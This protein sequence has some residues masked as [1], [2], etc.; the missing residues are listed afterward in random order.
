M[1]D[2]KNEIKNNTLAFIRRYIDRGWPV[3]PCN[4]LKTPRTPNGFYDAMTDMVQIQDWWNEYP[5]ALVGVPTGAVSGFWVIDIDM[6]DGKD[7]WASFKD[8]VLGS[9]EDLTLIQRTAS[10]GFHLLFKWNDE[11]PMNNGVDIFGPKSG[12]D[13]RGDGGY[14]IVAPSAINIEGSWI[15]YR[16]ND[17]SLKPAHMPRWIDKIRDGMTSV[18]KRSRTDIRRAFE[19]GIPEGARDNDLFKI[20]CLLRERDVSEETALH[21]VLHLADKCIP[22]ME[23]SEAAQKVESAYSYAKRQE[24]KNDFI[25]AMKRI[26]QEINDNGERL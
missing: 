11:S 20:A 5:T 14:I 18:P 21:T 17:E 8:N 22:P 3:F 7:G 6:K 15:Q 2:F 12:V 1:N 16:W 24:K 19:E 13:V 10:G 25:E 4:H 9:N 26:R 23:H